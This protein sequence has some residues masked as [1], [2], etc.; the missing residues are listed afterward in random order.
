MIRHALGLQGSFARMERNGDKV[1]DDHGR[2]TSS[3]ARGTAAFRP[4]QRIDRGEESGRSTPPGPVRHLRCKDPGSGRIASPRRQGPAHRGSL[5]RPAGLKKPL[6]LLDKLP[7]A[8]FLVEAGILRAAAAKLVRAGYTSLETLARASRED[9][10]SVPGISTGTI[11]KLEVLLGHPLR[12]PTAYWRE[13]GLPATYAIK[14]GKARIESVEALGRM[15]RTEIQALGIGNVGVWKC[16]ELLGRS[17]DYS[18]A[19]PQSDHGL[20]KVT[21][22]AELEAQR[23]RLLEM[24]VPLQTR[25]GDPSD[26][27]T[28]RLRLALWN[29]A[30]E[31]ASAFSEDPGSLDLTKSDA[32]TGEALYSYV[33]GKY[34]SVRL[35]DDPGDIHVPPYT[36][37]ECQLRVFH[38]YGRWFATWIKLEEDMSRP[39]WLTRELLVFE[40]DEDGQLCVR[41]V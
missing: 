10:L 13:K 17:L 30:R 31:L 34:F 29:A 35:L 38:E 41:E 4:Q 7:Q 15:S 22:F 20:P 23:R 16:E 2:S 19:E 39:E 37:E 1:W 25:R 27:A 3:H 18:P 33:V 11:D 8:R 24:L 6:T 12:S 36:P 40:I 14:L 5:G 9:L 32:A 28:E 21:A 26:N